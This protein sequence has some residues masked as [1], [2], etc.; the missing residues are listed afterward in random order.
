[1]AKWEFRSKILQ[2]SPMKICTNNKEKLLENF[3][4]LIFKGS[5]IVTGGEN[6]TLYLWEDNT[7]ASFLTINKDHIAPI[8]CLA[9][10][11]QTN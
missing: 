3:L 11:R 10:I 2:Y 6:G 9:S 7:I 8:L 5:K 1:M 4:C